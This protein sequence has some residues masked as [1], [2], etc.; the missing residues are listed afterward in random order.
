MI[1]L[2]FFFCLFLFASSA[3]FGQAKVGSKTPSISIDEWLKGDAVTEFKSGTVYL[4]EFWGTWC[5][6]CVDNIPH[7][8]ELQKKY[9]S[10][11]LVVIGVATHETKD[12]AFLMDWMKT[13]GD[14]MEYTVAYDSD[15][16][17]EKDWDTGGS[18]DFRLP[19]CFLIDSSGKVVFAG[20][21]ANKKLES[22]IEA[23]VS[24]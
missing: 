1:R 5:H 11:G 15:Q 19:V 16:S 3:S 24:K 20:H 4:V 21:P 17:M 13:N 10:Q 23:T 9:G 12:R 22:L 2:L 7:L 8:S 18:G 14:A 6:P